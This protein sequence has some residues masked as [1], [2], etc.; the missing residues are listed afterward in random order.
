MRAVIFVFGLAMGCLASADSLRV[1]ST[2]AKVTEMLLLLGAEDNLVGVDVTSSVPEALKRLPSVGYHRQLSAEGLLSLQPDLV[3]GSQHMGPE[4]TLNLLESAQIDL[5]Q[6]PAAENAEILRDQF[7]QVATTLGHQQ[8]ARSVLITLDKNIEQLSQQRLSG[9]R[10]VFLL[11][12]EA[13]KLRVAG[14]QTAGDAFIHLLG[15]E[16][17]VDFANYRNVSIESLVSLQ[18]DVIL[19]ATSDPDFSISDLLE[20]KPALKA[21]PAVQENRVYQV[22]GSTL[23]AGLSISSLNEAVVIT[24]A[25]HAP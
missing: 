6:L 16:N 9:Q 22:D 20:D 12:M 19:L 23:V 17:A 3:I 25:V 21:T 4:S 8:E 5:V 14:E 15:G 18:P 11:M 1:I 24:D 2:D 10:I 13:N 7:M